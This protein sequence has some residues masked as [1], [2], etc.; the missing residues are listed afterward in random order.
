MEQTKVSNYDEFKGALYDLVMQHEES[1]MIIYYSYD[2][3]VQGEIDLACAEIKGTDPV[4]AYSVSEI[5]VIPT[6][7]VTYFEID[8]SI[9]YKRTTQQV[10]SIVP[11]A[12]LREL[13]D[14]LLIIMSNYQDEAVFRTAMPGV[15]A[16]DIE[17]YVRET[18]YQNPRNIVMKPGMTVEIF[19]EGGYDRVFE[20]RFG[21]TQQ[22][23]I[24]RQ[25]SASLSESV[26]RNAEAAN[27]DNAAEI[28][29]SL[30]ENLIGACFYDEGKAKVISE[31]GTQNIATTA[32]GA[33]VVGSAVGEGFAMAYKALCEELGFDCRIVLGYLD[34][35]VHAWNIVPIYGDYYHI[36]VSMCAENGIETAFLKTDEDFEESYIWDTENAAS[37]HGTLT[38]ED[39]AGIL[40]EDETGEDGLA[41]YTAD[42]GE[43]VPAPFTAD[44]GEE[45]PE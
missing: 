27:G 32:Y 35:M 33:L 45:A 2:T 12:T 20:L 26:R 19:P 5:I 14:E 15:T 37:C 10:E 29:L 41:L 3:D 8:I 22:A 39:V 42:D 11:V 44:D 6:R 23:G 13:R 1:G 30:A 18:Y 21:N 4:G 17:I 31:H 25:Y 9:E 40:P 43:E 24:L 34:G 7:I 38:Y 36:D 16:E 28:L